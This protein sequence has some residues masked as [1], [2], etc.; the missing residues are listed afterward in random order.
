MD[1]TIAPY[2]AQHLSALQVAQLNDIFFSSSA[3]QSFA[4]PAARA[5]F[6]ERW[7]GLYVQHDA[8]HA[9]LAFDAESHVIGYVVGTIEDLAMLPRF[10][11]LASA[12]AFAALSRI[13]P[14][15]LHINLAAKA[16]NQ[17]IGAR[18]IE[19]FAAHA[20]AQ[21]AGGVHVVTSASSRNV[22]FYNRC[23]FHEAGRAAAGS[24]EMVFLAR[25]FADC[26]PAAITDL[27]PKAH[28]TKT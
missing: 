9:F 21:G 18:L 15:H 2:L 22:R 14:A 25:A 16:R 3:T 28:G 8:A 11:D 27:A 19:T 6:H 10:A 24:G 5:A 17:G 12:R 20:Q 13:Y 7:L 4:G 1:A 23:G 26:A